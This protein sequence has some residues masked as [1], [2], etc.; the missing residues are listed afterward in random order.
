MFAPHYAEPSPCAVVVPEVPLRA[1]P[2][3]KARTV[4]QL[5]LGEEFLLL[6]NVGGWA[7]GRSAH[8]D[9]VG[10]VPADTLGSVPAASHRVS[11]PLALVFAEPDIKAPVHARWPVAAR[12]SA[13]SEGDFLAT[14]QGFVHIRHALPLGTT[15]DPIA[16][17]ERLIGLPYLWGGRG[18]GGIDCSGLVQVALDFAGI[19]CPRDSDMQRDAVGELLIEGAAFRR[20]DLVFFPGHV[21]LMVDESRLIHAN[22]HWMAVTVEPL[23]DVVA[24]LAPTHDRP[25]IA[26][27][28][29][30]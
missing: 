1:E 5:A 22:A 21:G 28:R 3:Q 12:F 19:P 4:S 20:G 7:W 2:N 13:T 14:D 9:Y 10:Y 26:H 17:A 11:V 6:D 15:I 24:R 30:P 27:R 18:G 8:D 25:I 29:L 16:M 23:A